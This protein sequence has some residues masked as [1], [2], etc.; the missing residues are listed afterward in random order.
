MTVEQIPVVDAIGTNESTG[1][2]HLTISDH[3]AWNHEHMFTLQEKVNSYL[4]FVESGEIYSLYPG[5]AGRKIVIELVLKHRPSEEAAS[6]LSKVDKIIERSGL[7][8]RY[9]PL[10]SG[11]E[12][13]NG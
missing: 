10:A 9:S 4:A 6:F 3:L 1:A 13:D 7:S 5:A 8:F 2:V 11:Y 12:K